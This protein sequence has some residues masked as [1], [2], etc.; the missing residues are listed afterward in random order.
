[1]LSRKAGAPGL[2]PL[3]LLFY[4]MALIIIC[5][6]VIVIDITLYH[7]SEYV[8]EHPEYG[9]GNLL[10]DYSRIFY[11]IENLELAKEWAC[12]KQRDGYIIEYSLRMG[13]LKKLDYL[14]VGILYT[15]NISWQE[16][17]YPL[18]VVG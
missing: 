8:I 2:I 1:M 16:I 12:G 9:K 6:K 18:Q 5:D 15:S 7:G 10:N 3:E 14:F 4:F 17:P 13:G 11:C